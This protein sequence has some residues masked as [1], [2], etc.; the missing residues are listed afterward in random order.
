LR[1][2][3]AIY[4]RHHLVFWSNSAINVFH[5]SASLFGA[6]TLTTEF[7]QTEVADKNWPLVSTQRVVILVEKRD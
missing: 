1:F 7:V 6:T 4:T 2:A 5:F 3:A